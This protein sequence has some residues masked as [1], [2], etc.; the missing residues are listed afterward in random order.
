MKLDI[1][2]PTYNRSALLRATISSLLRARSGWIGSSPLD[3]R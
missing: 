3:C 1:V 2:V